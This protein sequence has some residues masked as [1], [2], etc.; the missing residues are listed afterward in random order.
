MTDPGSPNGHDE[1]EM[2][3]ER[4][5]RLLDVPPGRAPHLHD[6]HDFLTAAAAEPRL[7]A[8]CP[9]TS[10]QDLGFRRSVAETPSRALAWVR[11]F[12]EGRYLIAGPDRRG[13]H[14]P[15]PQPVTL[16]GTPPVPGALGPAPARESVALVLAVLDRDRTG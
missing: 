1:A 6:L 14:T 5:R 13:L 2:I 16:W 7:R 15:G 10:H 4:W 8:L 12:G 9:F 3:G 11:P